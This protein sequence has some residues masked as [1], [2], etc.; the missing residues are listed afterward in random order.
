MLRRRSLGM[1]SAPSGRESCSKVLEKFR[2]P[3]VRSCSE[4]SMSAN[5]IDR[6]ELLDPLRLKYVDKI[7]TSL[8]TEL[9]D[10]EAI[11]Q[12]LLSK[13]FIIPISG[14]SCKDLRFYLCLYILPFIFIIFRVTK[15]YVLFYIHYL[16][17]Y[18]DVEISILKLYP[19]F[20]GSRVNNWDK[21]IKKW[22]GARV[23]A[24]PMDS[25]SKQEI[26][27][28]LSKNANLLYKSCIK[29]IVGK[30]Y[31]FSLVNFVNPGLLG[32]ASEFKKRFENIILRY[33]DHI[34]II[35]GYNYLNVMIK[36]TV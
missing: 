34:L 12:R 27:N 3:L 4:N 11:I 9:C 13:P 7:A 18:Q 29:W 21:E 1:T 19:F 10:H 20:G 30:R 24:L 36:M 35:L 33:I 14:Y 16:F 2:S 28:K 17:Q 5:R 6:E 15:I 31:Y 8:S 32:T 22:L 23:N 26:T 25:G